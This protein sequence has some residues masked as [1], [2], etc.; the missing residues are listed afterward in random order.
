MPRTK[1]K[2]DAIPP[3]IRVKT[4]AVAIE[5]HRKTAERFGYSQLAPFVRRLL[6]AADKANPETGVINFF[7]GSD[8]AGARA[9]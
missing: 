3:Q 4:D 7:R 2:A 5:R 6:D 9:A 1:R 8:D